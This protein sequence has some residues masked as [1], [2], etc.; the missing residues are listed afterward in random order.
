[1][2][3]LDLLRGKILPTMIRFGAPLM[4]TAFIQMAYNLTDIAWIGRIGTDAV[5]AAGQV[6]FLMWIGSS[7]A[8]IPRVGM[9][10]LV[11]QYYGAGDR[12]RAQ[13]S[14][15]NGLWLSLLMGLAYG[16]LLL[17]F[18]DV[19]I[20]FYQLD[21]AVNR[22]TEQY[23][24]II[25]LG[26]PLF[27]INP[28]LSGAYNSLGNSRLPFRVNTLGLLINII[29]DPFLIFGWGP[30]PALGIQGA[31]IATVF[32]Q[33]IVFGCFAYVIARS[34]DLLHHSRPLVF[35]PE[36]AMLKEMT[37]LGFPISLQSNIHALI[38][39]LL[40]RSVASYGALPLAVASVGSNIESISWMTTEGFAAAIT[41]FTGQNFGAHFF[42]RV[43]DIYKTSM[44]SVAMI[45]LLA[46]FILLV[47]RYQL[48]QLFIP[49]DPQAIELGAVYLFIFGLS[50]LFMSI[51]IGGSGFL[52]GIGDTRTP[53][54]INSIFNLLRIP[55]AML[56]MG[57][58]GVAGIW[59]AMSLSSVI[60]GILIFILSHY[61]LKHVM[62]R[63]I[64][65]VIEELV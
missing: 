7:L 52:N 6:G 42:D 28:V 17:L 65:P 61:R 16:G 27:F 25:A 11:A 3:Q 33:C 1:M 47:F 29:G 8:L 38:S 62:R 34:D 30:F 26:M 40:N 20:Q 21:A 58:M 24:V 45:G 31:A 12:D 14:I 18:K 63:E 53:A 2:K 51:E 36:A 59:V 48:F 46:T 4:G 50:Q 37:R 55:L 39:V 5:A 35:R 41:A 56:L 44:K 10:V 49:N 22:L 43:K 64:A 23:L 9:S 32:A 19:L 54:L 15:N 57:P 60:K 13:L